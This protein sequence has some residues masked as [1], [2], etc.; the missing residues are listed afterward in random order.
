M[1]VCACSVCDSK[2]SQRIRVKAR[3]K[4][5]IPKLAYLRSDHVHRLGFVAPSLARC[6]L[7]GG[8]SQ[9]REAL[10]RH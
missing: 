10:L 6:A 1:C 5:K 4:K 9:V 8:V 3:E 7:G 2:R